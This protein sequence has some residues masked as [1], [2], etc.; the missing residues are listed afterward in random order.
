MGC[1]HVLD[2]IHAERFWHPPVPVEGLI[3]AR[4]DRRNGGYAAEAKGGDSHVMMMGMDGGG[5]VFP[6]HECGLG[7]EDLG[8]LR[9]HLQS[10]TAWSYLSLVGCRV[11]CLVDN[12]EWQEGLV[13]EY[14]EATGKHRVAFEHVGQSRWMSM[15]RSAFFIIRRPPPPPPPPSLPSS[16]AETKDPSPSPSPL[17]SLPSSSSPWTYTEDLSLDY[18]RAQ[19]LMHQAYGNQIQETG[20][21]TR[22]HL[23]VTDSD[24]AL[25]HD[26]QSSLLYGELLP[27]GINK[28]L[29]ALRL[30]GAE[31]A[32]VY[33]L[34]MGIGK[35]AMQVFLQFSSTAEGG[36]GRG[37]EPSPEEAGREGGRTRGRETRLRRVY[38]VE[39]SSARFVMAEAAAHRLCRERPREFRVK[40]WVR[41]R[42]VVVESIAPAT[43]GGAGGGGEYGGEGGA[44]GGRE[45]GGA[46]LEMEVG[47]LLEVQGLETAD[48]VLLETDLGATVY[49]DLCVMLRRL[50]SG[51][52]AFTYLDLRMIWGEGLGGGGGR[53]GRRRVGVFP[54]RQLEINRV[55][56]DRYATSWS[57]NRGHHFYLWMKVLES[58]I[59][60]LIVPEGHPEPSEWVPD[61]GYGGG[62]EDGR[63]V[64][65]LQQQQQQQQGKHHDRRRQRRPAAAAVGAA[66]AVAALQRQHSSSSSS[67]YSPSR[68]RE[69][70]G[71]EGGRGR[72]SGSGRSL[73]ASWGKTMRRMMGGGGGGGAGGG[74]GGGGRRGGGGSSLSSGVA[75][76]QRRSEGGGGEK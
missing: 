54:F 6:C 41:G 60:E 50:K 72:S 19:A 13:V 27:R 48:I 7:F 24:R 65:Y 62:R 44:G 12:R 52:R 49:P 38:G 57:V 2:P 29:G 3:L 45:G 25:A 71:R 37:S 10:K 39:L 35:V 69:E 75:S 14:L 59:D 15:L 66:A 22:G 18:A 43:G 20:H 9:L 32:V 40:E 4:N 8:E 23:C 61:V 31:A 68:E 1:T 17:S 70:G 76:P 58:G 53:K 51:A 55:V 33:E 34:G 67:S 63:Q 73:F 11:S 56:S 16:S 26:A 36:E 42:R 28:A 5:S 47:N 30:R 74:G 64:Q 21:K 46:I